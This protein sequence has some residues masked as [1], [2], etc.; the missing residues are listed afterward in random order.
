MPRSRRDITLTSSGFYGPAFWCEK[1]HEQREAGVIGNSY[2]PGL[3]DDAKFPPI[4]RRHRG[5]RERKCP[6]N[7]QNRYE[8][9][10]CKFHEKPLI[11]IGVTPI[12][13]GKARACTASCGNASPSKKMLQDALS[14]CVVP[15]QSIEQ[16]FDISGFSSPFSSSSAMLPVD[17][18]IFRGSSFDQS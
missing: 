17:V 11:I 9:A 14:S 16:Y 13:S 3:R 7:S 8:N 2:S 5:K 12:G 15:A 6:C 4:D 1:H 18:A 10:F